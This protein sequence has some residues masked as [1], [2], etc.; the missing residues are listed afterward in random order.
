M[1]RPMATDQSGWPLRKA[2]VPSMGSTIQIRRRIEAVGVVG[3]L[4]REPAGLGQ[5]PRQA[6]LEEG[7][8]LHV[9][10]RDG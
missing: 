4:L 8:H 6:H 1:R 5:S 7:V 9:G 2:R 10:L 3:G